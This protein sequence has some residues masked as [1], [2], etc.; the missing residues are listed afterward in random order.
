MFNISPTVFPKRTTTTATL[1]IPACTLWAVGASGAIRLSKGDGTWGDYISDTSDGSH[2]LT[3]TIYVKVPNATVDGAYDLN[4][5]YTPAGGGEDVLGSIPIMVGNLSLHMESL[6]FAFGQ[7]AATVQYS[8]NLVNDTVRCGQ[9]LAGTILDHNYRFEVE[10][11]VEN[12]AKSAIS[13]SSFADKLVNSL[14]QYTVEYDY[15]LLH[16]GWIRPLLTEHL[17]EISK[18]LGI[19]IVLR[20]ADFY[21]ASP[22][23]LGIYKALGKMEQTFVGTFAEHLNRLLGWSDSVPGMTYNLYIDNGI[24]YIV[25]Q[26]YEQN[27]LTPTAWAVRPTLTHTIRRTEWSE[28][29]TVSIPKEVSSNDGTS[30]S[31]PFNGTI[32]WGTASL[33]YE[34]GYLM[35]E[36]DGN[37]TTTYTY[38]TIGDCKR[39][40]TR[41]MVDTDEYECIQTVYSYESTENQWYLAK[42]VQTTY[43]GTDTTGTVINTQTTTHHLANIEGWYGTTVYD[44]Y[45][46]EVSHSVSQGAP[47]NKVSQYT[48]DKTND[49]LKNSSSPSQITVQLNG[50]AKAR[51]TYPVASTATLQQIA[52]ALD[53]YEGK[54]MVTLSGTIVGGNHIYTFNDKISY[55]GNVYQLVSNNVSRTPTQIR[56]SITA[57]RYILN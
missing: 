31:V 39:M 3:V 52:T 13:G 24:I 47:G 53:T 6:N 8:A 40:V 33:T 34:D 56:Q 44:E 46:A 10:R 1:T 21:P 28:P 20:G 19:Q 22:L 55:A 18:V 54:E 23:N 14:I 16:L 29:V 12:G 57:V 5:Q 45:G 38:Q 50:V 4:Y 9:N 17:A 36:V 25:Q 15:D 51:Q 2:D 30:G 37:K 26:G 35:Q 32:T 27:T 48:I 42:E 43:T 7:R 11:I 49:A 41:T